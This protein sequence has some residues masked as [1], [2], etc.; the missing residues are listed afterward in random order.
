MPSEVIKVTV[1][2]TLSKMYSLSRGAKEIKSLKFYAKAMG[3][4]A[5]S[6]GLVFVLTQDFQHL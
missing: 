3:F 6:A 1:I 4:T 2:L 5:V